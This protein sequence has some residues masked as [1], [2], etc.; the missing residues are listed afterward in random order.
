MNE[1]LVKALENGLWAALFCTLFAYMLKDSRARED[2]YDSALDALGD[3]LREA[4][5][6]FGICKLIKSDCENGVRLSTAVKDDTER[7]ICDIERLEAQTESIKS[8][9]EALKAFKERL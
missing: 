9:T 2:R 4:I 6:A 5:E 7:I 1:I 3:R 8:E